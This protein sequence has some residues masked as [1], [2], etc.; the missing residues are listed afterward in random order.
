MIRPLF[1]L[2]FVLAAL[3]GYGE[4]RTVT[5]T[6]WFADQ[7]CVAPRAAKGVFTPSNPEC[8]RKCIEEGSAVVFLPDQQKALYTVKSYA[9]AKDDLGWHVEVTATADD[10]GGTL[11]VTSVKRLEYVGAACSRSARSAKKQ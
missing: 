4:S 8:A 6:G 2:A 11:T 1:A 5:W 9:A 10:E 7:R 3:P